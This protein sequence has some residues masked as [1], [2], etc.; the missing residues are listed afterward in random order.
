MMNWKIKK[1]NFYFSSEDI[2]NKDENENESGEEGQLILVA[3]G[4]KITILD[5][6]TG[7]LKVAI[8]PCGVIIKDTEDIIDES[9]FDIKKETFFNDNSQGKN[10]YTFN[11]GNDNEYEKPKHKYEKPKK[12]KESDDEGMFFSFFDEGEDEKPKQKKKE[13]DDEMGFSFFDDS[14]DE[15]PKHKYEKPKQKK[16]ESDDEIIFSFFD[17]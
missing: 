15:K 16:K 2:P 5:R 10:L 14:E 6:I 7:F 1:N 12:K 13:S 4:D 3:N 8:G 11:T 9:H 17:E